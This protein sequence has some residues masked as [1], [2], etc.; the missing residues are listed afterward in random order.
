MEVE[1]DDEVKEKR[2]INATTRSVKPTLGLFLR[3]DKWKGSFFEFG[4]FSSAHH[5]PG[6]KSNSVMRFLRFRL[7]YGRSM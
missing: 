6:P 5:H 7:K 1:N 2:E 4:F 3:N